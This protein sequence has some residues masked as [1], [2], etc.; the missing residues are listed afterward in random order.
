MELVNLVRSV[1][2]QNV[3]CPQLDSRDSDVILICEEGKQLG[4]HKIVL[5]I[6]SIFFR[7]LLKNDFIPQDRTC[8]TLIL[9]EVSLHEAKQVLQFL[10]TGKTE[11]NIDQLEKIIKVSAML[12]IKSL[13]TLLNGILSKKR[14]KIVPENVQSEVKKRTG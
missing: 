3:V 14:I 7:D 2:D 4:A 5:S 12:Q 11:I 9:S 10:Y 8:P 1:N 13:Q 6:G